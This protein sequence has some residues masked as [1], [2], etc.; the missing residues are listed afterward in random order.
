[1]ESLIDFDKDLFFFLNGLHTDWL[2]QVMFWLSEKKVW[3]P[4]Y[5]AIAAW[6]IKTYKWK[7]LIYIAAI[8]AAIGL[9]DF[10]TSGIMKGYFERFRPSRITSGGQRREQPC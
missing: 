6:I 10:V 3:I 4:F 5:V 9:T 2:D 1:M 7:G 8:G